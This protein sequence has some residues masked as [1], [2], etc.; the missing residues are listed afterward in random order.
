MNLL[1]QGLLFTGLFYILGLVYF[2]VLVYHVIT[3]TPRFILDMH[4]YHK[5]N[6]MD[7]RDAE[8][9]SRNVK[10]AGMNVRNIYVF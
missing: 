7:S 8:D 5:S 6:D 10:M 1:R 3:I 4:M 9:E 2:K